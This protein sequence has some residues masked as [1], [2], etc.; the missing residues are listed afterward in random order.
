MTERFDEIT[1]IDRIEF[2]LYGN[3]EIK[4][5]S[6]INDTYGINIAET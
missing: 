1:N 5:A 6:A 2:T 4:R 3:G